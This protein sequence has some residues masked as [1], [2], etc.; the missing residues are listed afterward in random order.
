MSNDVKHCSCSK[1]DFH[2]VALYI[3]FTQANIHYI[4]AREVLFAGQVAYLL[5]FYVFCINLLL[6]V[7][8]IGQ[9]DRLKQLEKAIKA[10]IHDPIVGSNNWIGYQRLNS[11]LMI[12]VL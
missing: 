11:I 6:V 7:Q 12:S 9:L 1:S 10:L 3:N 8:G 4:L 2:S 5:L